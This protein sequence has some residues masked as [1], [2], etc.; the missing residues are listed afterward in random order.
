MRKY[1]IYIISLLYILSSCAQF[2]PPTGGETDKIGPKLLS[3]FPEN[4][5]IN[6]KGKT[7]ELTFDE[8]V[9]IAA[10]K[11]ELVISPIVEGNF[12]VKQKDKTIKLNFE[13]PFKDSTTYTLNFRSGIK[14]LNERNPS[15]NLKLVF[16]TF[17]KIDSLSLNGKISDIQTKKYLNDITV[18]LYK[19]DTLPIQKK[20][21]DYFIKTDSSGNYLFENIKDGK[22][23]LFA[24]SDKN[25]NLIYDQKNETT[26]FYPDTINLNKNTTLPDVEVYFANRLK[27]K[28]KKTISRENEFIIQFDKPTRKTDIIFESDSLMTQL[29][30]K[31]SENELKIFKMRQPSKDTLLTT[32]ILTD[33][34]LNTDT[35]KQ[36]VFFNKP[37]KTQKNKIETIRL[38]SSIKN[39]QAVTSDLNYILDFEYPI[40]GFDSTKIKFK[41]DTLEKEKPT[42][43]WITKT[44]LKISVITKAKKETDLIVLPNAFINY[45]GDTNTLI[46]IKNKILLA[47][48]LAKLEGSTEDKKKNKI[49]QLINYSTR[50]IEDEKL[51]TDKFTFVNIIPESYDIKI[52]FD[53]NNNKIWDAGDINTKKLPEKILITKEPIKIRANFELKDV[54]IK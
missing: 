11:Q 4:K 39:G 50:K 5:T 2:V 41:T 29:S 3:S 31:H 19:Q 22:Y 23:F 45:R 8:Y 51:F 16:S 28:I 49:A 37:L 38:T 35:L 1:Y 18:G 10:L 7:V 17:S 20:K 33:S 44:E 9:E 53:D 48:D 13:K 25:L 54:L 21:P 52:I 30:T 46:Q 40:T 43:T 36:K 26:G 42:I 24:F 32:I 14:D 6:Y 47:S 27:N 34:L 15:K 12:T